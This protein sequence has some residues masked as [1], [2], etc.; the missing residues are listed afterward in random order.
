MEKFSIFISSSDNYSDIWDIFFDLFHRFWPEYNGKI[1]LQTQKKNYIHK[2]LNI[3][4]TNIGNI[5]EF[6]ASLRA[7]LN[8]IE[9]ENI[10]FIMID[11]IFMGKVNHDKI[12]EYYKF[13]ITHDVDSLRLVEEKFEHYNNTE[14]PDIKQCLPPA[15]HRFFS[16]QIA[17]WKKN[18]LKE[19]TLPHESP[20]SSEWYGDK[21]AHLL[22]L[23]LY[24]IK[25]TIQQPI[26]YDLRGCLHRGKWLN[27]AI[28]F[29]NSIN[30]KINYNQRGLYT[31]EYKSFSTYL[32]LSVKLKLDGIKGSYWNL[33]KLRLK[34]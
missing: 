15:K 24:S 11:Y 31:N 22:P 3:I 19:M 28:D 25:E 6:G 27:N 4:C 16:Y 33:L 23:K 30:Y 32:K 7:G 8:K 20:W 17:F 13:F 12:M 21:R 34:K 18:K 1:Y 5:K 14:C 26:P 10:L 2:N 9:D 29:L